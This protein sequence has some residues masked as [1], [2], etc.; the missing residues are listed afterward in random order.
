MA[1]NACTHLGD[2]QKAQ[3]ISN[4]RDEANPRTA[5]EVDAAMLSIDRDFATG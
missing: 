2:W 5:K 4:G 1:D 3:A